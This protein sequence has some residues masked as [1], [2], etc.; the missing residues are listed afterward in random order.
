[1]TGEGTIAEVLAGE[2]RWHLHAGDFRAMLA[3]LPDACLDSCVCDPPYELGFM[4]RKWDASGIAYDVDGWRSVLRVL[5]PGGHLL[6]FGGDRTHHRMMVA[7][8]DAGFDIRTCVYWLFASGFPKSLNVSAALDGVRCACAH[9]STQTTPDSQDDCPSESRCDDAQPHPASGDGPTN[10]PSQADARARSHADLREDVQ[11]PAPARTPG[12]SP[13]VHHATDGS[14]GQTSRLQEA[15]R[16]TDNLRSDTQE[17]TSAEQPRAARKTAFGRSDNGRSG[18]DSE[19]ASFRDVTRTYQTCQPCGR[20][21]VPDG[22]GTALKPAAEI[23]VV[24]RKPLIGTVA[25]NVL[26]H[27]TGGLNIDGCRVPMD[28]DDFAKLA[29]GVEV[30]RAKGGVIAG[31]VPMNTSDLSGANPANEAGR[32]PANVIHDGSPEVLEAFAR[33]GDRPSGAS[34]GDGGRIFGAGGGPTHDGYPG[35]SGSAA[36]F[37]FTAKASR[38]ER[39]LGCEGLPTHTAAEATHSKEGQAR[40]DSPRTGAGRTANAIRNVHPTVKPLA[41]MRYLCR[42]VTPPGGTVLDPFSGSGTCGMAALLEGFRYVGMELLEEHAT[43]A[44]ARISH[45][46]RVDVPEEKTPSGASQL[47]LFGMVGT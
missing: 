19:Q 31:L 29:A 8:E 28:A 9:R 33:Y 18:D 20:P 45:P 40:L 30:I 12:H 17:N 39:E 37:F 21:V 25:A 42:L 46:L 2:A 4:G 36:R 27:G 15:D 5:K 38:A 3:T 41:L 6:A 26:A 47:G 32:W 1:M 35:D 14:L 13:N 44:R 43:I 34:I 7:I 11:V 22:L 23:I 10:A 16:A 24:A